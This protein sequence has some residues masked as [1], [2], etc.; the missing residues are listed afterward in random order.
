MIM[1]GEGRQRKGARASLSFRGSD[2]RLLAVLGIT[3][4]SLSQAPCHVS[5]A[6][7]PYLPP[8]RRHERHHP[9][10]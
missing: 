9:Y 3:W 4:T 10:S 1:D 7:L 8:C 5:A 6:A 2:T